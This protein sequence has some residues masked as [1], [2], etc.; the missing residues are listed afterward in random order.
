[1]THAPHTLEEVNSSGDT[2]L[3]AAAKQGLES[4]TKLLLALGA[5]FEHLHISWVKDSIS[6]LLHVAGTASGLRWHHVGS[7]PPPHLVELKHLR[8]SEAIADKAVPLLGVTLSKSSSFSRRS[9]SR[10]LVQ[11]IV[12][13]PPA[14][15]LQ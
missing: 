12:E 6:Q 13:R 2:P 10:E 1:M 3:A 11:E 7:R 8:L 5:R 4:A 14:L 9:S 15:T